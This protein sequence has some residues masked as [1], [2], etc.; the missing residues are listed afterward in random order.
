M[1]NILFYVN[2]CYEI[3]CLVIT[4]TSLF[5]YLIITEFFVETE[6]NRSIIRIVKFIT[7]AVVS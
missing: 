3:F 4:S 7:Y 6:Y 2:K 5:F 1:G